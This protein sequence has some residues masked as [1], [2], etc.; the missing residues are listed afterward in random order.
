M[1]YFLPL[2]VLVFV[3]INLGLSGWAQTILIDPGH[4]GDDH[5]AKG[6]VYKKTRKGKVRKRVYFEKDLVLELSKKIAK[7]LKK[8]KYNVFLS[9]SIDRTISLE[10]RAL[11]AEKVSADLVISIHMNSVFN[12]VSNGFETYYLDNHD[13]KAIRRLEEIENKGL[14]GDKLIIQQILNDLVIQ[15]TVHRSKSLAR[16]IHKYI[17][18]SLRRRYR[19]KDRGIKPGSFYILALSK[20]PGILLEVGFLSCQKELLKMKSKRF[21]DMYAEAIAKGIQGYY[22]SNKAKNPSLF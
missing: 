6:V 2:L 22:R 13:D 1:N 17:G 5:G 14:K 16:N 3:N 8:K 21:Q 11:M 19:M 7:K 10:D 9:R 18:K 4:G 12:K 20:R 15:R